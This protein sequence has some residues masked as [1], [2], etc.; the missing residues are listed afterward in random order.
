VARTRIGRIST[1]MTFSAPGAAG[2]RPLWAGPDRRPR[3]LAADHDLDRLARRLDVAFCGGIE[4]G[5]DQRGNGGL[6]RLL[7]PDQPLERLVSLHDRA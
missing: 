6:A 1:A 2:R 3:R 7:R 5:K 4:A